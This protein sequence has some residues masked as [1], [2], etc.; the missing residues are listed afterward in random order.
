M[1]NFKKKDKFAQKVSTLGQSINQPLP[2]FHIFWGNRL[3]KVV[4]YQK[5]LWD[6]PQLIKLI[7]I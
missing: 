2:K 5:H 1:C 6:A 4:H 3:I 7:K